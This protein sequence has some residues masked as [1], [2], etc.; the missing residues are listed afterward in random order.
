[1]WAD[2]GVHLILDNYGA[3]KT[4]KV[5]QWL[6]RHPR[7]HCHF[8]PTCSSWINLVERFFA[9]NPGN[10]RDMVVGWRG[11]A[12]GQERRGCECRDMRCWR[13]SP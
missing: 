9:D 1:M 7:F 3:H 4:A 8:T 10:N 11:V 2:L 13:F 6:L 5:K 12:G